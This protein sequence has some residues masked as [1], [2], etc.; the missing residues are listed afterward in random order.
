[1]RRRISL[2]IGAV[3]VIGTMTAEVL[4]GEIG[5]LW[6]GTPAYYGLVFVFLITGFG[7]IWV[8]TDARVKI[9]IDELE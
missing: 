6:L 4:L 5:E 3:F 2:I 8:W 7:F 9:D 1:M